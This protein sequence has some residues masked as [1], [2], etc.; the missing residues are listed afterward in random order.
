MPSQVRGQLFRPLVAGSCRGGSSGRYSFS[1]PQNDPYT[2]NSARTTRLRTRSC[3]HPTR[4]TRVPT[5]S[6]TKWSSVRY[7]LRW[8]PLPSISATT[9]Y[10]GKRLRRRRGVVFPFHGRTMRWRHMR[11]Q[12]QERRRQQLVCRR[13]IHL[14]WSKVAEEAI[15]RSAKEE[16]IA[17]ALLHHVLKVHRQLRRHHRRPLRVLWR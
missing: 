1:S 7:P 11:Q 6:L 5:F 16:V 8:R 17:W 13:W 2:G 9:T 15:R 10:R 12:R 4:A 14:I 3:T